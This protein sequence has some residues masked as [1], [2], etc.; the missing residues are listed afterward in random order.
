MDDCSESAMS[1]CGKSGFNNG[2]ETNDPESEQ[3][4]D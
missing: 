3:N 2:M 4:V 1:T